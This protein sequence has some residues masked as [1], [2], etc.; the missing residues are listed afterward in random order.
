M[1]DIVCR[2]K[3]I[4][5]WA[6]VACAAH[7][8]RTVQP[9]LG[10]YWPQVTAE[11]QD[12]IQTAIRLIE[13]SAVAGYPVDGLKSAHIEVL[14]TAGAALLP[15]YGVSRGGPGPPNENACYIAS[16]SAKVAERGVWAAMEGKGQ[17]EN[18][19]AEAY[20][21]TSSALK[22]AQHESVLGR[23]QAS[24]IAVSRIASQNKWVDDT[25][26]PTTLFDTLTTESH[27]KLWWR[28]W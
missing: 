6:R 23:L 1:D 12:S 22:R 8:A 2:I 9:L 18:A 25:P 17:S 21:F 4:P 10:E 20:S 13:Q 7:L 28:F 15:I 16:F 11:R 14:K 24:L 5:H 3:R 27:Q 19:L 26:V